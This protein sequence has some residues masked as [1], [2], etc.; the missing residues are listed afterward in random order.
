MLHGDEV[1]ALNRAGSSIRVFDAAAQFPD[2]D[3]RVRRVA[4]RDRGIPLQLGILSLSQG[5]IG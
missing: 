5:I 3:R 2:A 1:A 4:V